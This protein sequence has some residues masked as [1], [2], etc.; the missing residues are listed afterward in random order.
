MSTRN[1]I[2][3][4][5]WKFNKPKVVKDKKREDSKKICRQQLKDNNE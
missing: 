5:I 2:A 1:P 3:K 4:N